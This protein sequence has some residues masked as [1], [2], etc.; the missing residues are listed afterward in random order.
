VREGKAEILVVDDTPENLELLS[1]ELEKQGY[2]VRPAPDGEMA[3]RAAEMNP[4]D[5]VLLDI[6]M[7]RLDGYEVCRQLKARPSLHEIPVIFLSALDD[8]ADKLTAFEVG[9]VDYVTKP[10]HF[11]EVLARV[12]T[13]LA[14]RSTVKAL[15]DALDEVQTLRGL[16]PICSHCKSVRDDAGFWHAVEA[17][18]TSRSEVTFSH[19]IC[20]TCVREQFADRLTEEQLREI[21]GPEEP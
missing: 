16:I 12:S 19:G 2:R 17:Y 3:L 14:L 1:Q 13:H 5:L 6:R 4:P 15:R 20:P 18:F 9:G 8:G 7:P 21:L 11:P 10:F